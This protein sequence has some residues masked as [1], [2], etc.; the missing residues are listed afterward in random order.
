MSTPDTTP[1]VTYLRGHR[2]EIADLALTLV[3]HDTQ[4]PPGD[5]RDVVAWVESFFSELGIETERVVSNPEKPN[6]IATLPGSSERTLLLEGH[7]DTVPFEVAEQDSAARQTQSDDADQ[8]TYDPL[9]ERDGDRIYGRGAT[10]MKGAVAAMLAVAKAYVETDTIPESTIVFAFVSD[11]EVAGKAGLPTLLDQRTLTADACVI[12]ETTCEDGRHSVAV[13]DRGSIWLT[14]RASGKSAHGSRPMLGTN[15][16]RSLW[17][18][19]EDVESTLSELQFD[20]DPVVQAIVDESVEYYEPT[21]GAPS[22]RELFDRPSVN[23]GV[24]S[25]GDRVNVVPDVAEAKLD[26]RLT[27]GVD[28]RCVLDTIQDVVSDHEAVEID[29]VSWSIGTY[30]DPDGPLANAVAAVGS[31]VTG[32]RVY[33]RSAT[34]G[35]DAKRLRNTGIPTVEFGLGTNTAHAVDEFTTLDALAGNAEVYARLPGE[36]ARKLDTG[37]GASGSTGMSMLNT[38]IPCSYQLPDDTQ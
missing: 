24:I 4:N 15:A 20:F 27:A 32:D 38:I 6:L 26:I 2:E 21:F 36:L 30:E 3:G 17:A 25:G 18:A 14:L 23:L 10:D 31:E 35:G 28:S 37:T 34:G 1:A 7:L 5:T 22:A 8:W 11:E 19:I 33:R 16:I 29:D 13:A 9:G 12:G